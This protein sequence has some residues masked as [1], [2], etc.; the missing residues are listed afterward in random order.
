[1]I[2]VN[3]KKLNVL[4]LEELSRMSTHFDT[5]W[6]LITGPGIRLIVGSVYLKL[7]YK[8]AITEFVSM[9]KKAQTISKNL[10]R[11]KGIS[12]FGDLN[13]RHQLW[14]DTCN[15][16]YGN[17]LV[18]QLDFQEYVISAAKK[19][20]F[21][22][23]NG[24]SCIDLHIST[25]SG[26]DAF[27]ELETDEEAELFSGAPIRGHVPI[28]T[29]LSTSFA[30]KDTPPPKESLNLDTMDSDSWTQKLESGLSTQHEAWN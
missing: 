14:G 20:T 1:M 18:K 6:G 2:L 4:P 9:L 17:E 3:N 27:S 10:D 5:A 25:V 12:V 23:A 24:N 15:N 7:A 19:P 22:S 16:S 28:L 29:S 11:A 30:R 26:T 21:L 8:P 13:A